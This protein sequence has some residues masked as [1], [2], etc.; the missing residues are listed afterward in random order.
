MEEDNYNKEEIEFG[1]SA[2]CSFCGA[3]IFVPQDLLKDRLLVCPFCKKEIPN[4]FH[5]LETKKRRSNKEGGSSNKPKSLVAFLIMVAI[6]VTIAGIWYYSSTDADTKNIEHKIHNYDLRT[7]RYYDDRGEDRD[8]LRRCMNLFEINNVPAS[9]S[10]VGRLDENGK[11]SDVYTFK[12]G[13]N[14]NFITGLEGGTSRKNITYHTFDLAKMVVIFS[15]IVDGYR[16]NKSYP[17]SGVFVE[18]KSGHTIYRIN[19]G[20]LGLNEIWF[21]PAIGNI[22]YKYQDGRQIYYIK[23]VEI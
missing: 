6:G 18:N 1:N 17:I 16:I 7:Y 21:S 15:K 3:S 13:Y 8:L 9:G 2:F 22:G 14:E 19:V 10:L 12:S 5:V 4:P 20:V 23:V 11:K